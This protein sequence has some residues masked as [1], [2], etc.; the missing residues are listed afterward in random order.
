MLSSCEWMAPSCMAVLA[1][2]IA[3][4]ITSVRPSGSA[5]APDLFPG[6]PEAS[7]PAA[8]R[9]EPLSLVGLVQIEQPLQPRRRDRVFHGVRLTRR[10][11]RGAG[12]FRYAQAYL[13]GSQGWN[14]G[15]TRVSQGV[16]GGWFAQSRGYCLEACVVHREDSGVGLE[17]STA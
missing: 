1:R 2:S 6:T 7:L 17:L 8:V 13:N 14:F 11:L 15:G 5:V 3:V 16:F 4:R 9:L 10:W 12:P